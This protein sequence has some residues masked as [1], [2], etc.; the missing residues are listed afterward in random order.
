[1]LVYATTEDFGQWI[2]GDVPAN[3]VAL[4]RSASMIITDELSNTYYATDDTGLPTDTATLQ[5]FRDATCAQAASWI[6][7]KIDPLAGGVVTS[8]GIATSKALDGASIT[9]S[10]SAAASAARS[11]ATN[12]LCPQAVTILR[13]AG[14]LNTRVWTY[15]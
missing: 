5:A 14:L 9:Y 8:S 11:A 1:M 7:L 15:G 13:Q 4:L 6:A 3:A 12:A 2:A 10:D